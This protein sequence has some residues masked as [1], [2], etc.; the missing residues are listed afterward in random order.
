M[1]SP[2]LACVAALIGFRD[3]LSVRG[4]G[5]LQRS[6]V[7]VLLFARP[8]EALRLLTTELTVAVA[9]FDLSNAA[10]SALA[11]A[12]LEWLRGLPPPAAPRVV[13]ALPADNH[14]SV[15]RLSSLRRRT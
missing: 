7:H 2:P 1:P 12:F 8:A 11:P 14:S 6:G 9:V 4:A 15:L 5:I 13:V 3:P 10:V